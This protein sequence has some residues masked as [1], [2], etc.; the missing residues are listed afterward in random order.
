[1]KNKKF[2]FLAGFFGLI[3]T[4]LAVSSLVS[5][6]EMVKGFNN[7]A[8]MDPARV[9]ARQAHQAEMQIVLENGDYDA[10]KALV[11]SRP[12]ITDLVTEDNFD[13]FVAMHQARQ[14]GDDEAAQAIAAE[15]GF[16]AE[17]KGF[18]QGPRMG[19][20]PGD[21]GCLTNE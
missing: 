18:G 2:Y 11:D 12:R 21:R 20:G 19:H 17:G 5:A 4:T 10:W 9:E 14:A 16:P 8:N 3:V 1:M 6:Q 7:G 13:Q 15:L